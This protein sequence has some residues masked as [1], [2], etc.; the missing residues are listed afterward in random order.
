MSEIKKQFIAVRA[1]IIK[2]GKILNIRESKNYKGG[3]QHGKYDFP[4]GKVKIGET[5][6]EAIEREVKEEV[7]IE[8]EIGKLFWTNEWRPI[9]KGE[10]VQIIGIYFFC[11]PKGEKIRLGEDF[12]D[13][14]WISPDEYKDYPIVEGNRGA[15]E[16]L[17][18]NII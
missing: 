12:D 14:K 17:K 18:E 5:L 7:G 9:V 15:F 3:S 13:Y 6:E 10:K 16:I 4:G 11:K 8:V 2:D 1:V